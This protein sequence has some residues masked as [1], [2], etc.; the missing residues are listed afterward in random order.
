MS[1]TIKPHTV[2]SRDRREFGAKATWRKARKARLCDDGGCD[3]VTP[4]GEHYWVTGEY[5]SA[6]Q[7][8]LTIC[9]PCADTPTRP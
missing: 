7:R 6:L 5:S 9:A 8:Y 4:P 2:A 1:R 3:G